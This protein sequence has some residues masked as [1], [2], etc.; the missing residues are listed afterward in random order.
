RP[1]G[2]STSPITRRLDVWANPSEG[3]RACRVYDESGQLVAGEW[4]GAGGEHSIYRKGTAALER[5]GETGLLSIIE[6]GE[7]WRIALSAKDFL[8]LI[9]D[10]QAG[11]VEQRDNSYVVNYAFGQSATVASAS[12]VLGKSRLD[13]LEETLVVRR[14]GALT[15]YR[16]VV[17]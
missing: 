9:G 4:T 15:Q 12:L 7:V 16:L 5:S 10:P 1:Q 3:L 13:P 8:T 17:T 14:A 11:S 2:S 6:S